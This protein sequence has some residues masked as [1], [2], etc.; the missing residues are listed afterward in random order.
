M[1]AGIQVNAPEDVP[2]SNPPLKKNDADI[3]ASRS[4]SAPQAR[5][6]PLKKFLQHDG[7][8][9]RYN[10][11]CSYNK[12]R[13]I[14]TISMSSDLHKTC[15]TFFSLKKKKI[16]LHLGPARRRRH[17]GGWADETVRFAILPGRRHDPDYWCG[18]WKQSETRIV[19]FEPSPRSSSLSTSKI[20]QRYTLVYYS[21]SH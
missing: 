17:I 12:N 19:Q 9:L 2:E 18:I 8:I 5:N 16:W 7:Q 14:F 11:L 10:K 13:S 6:H 21:P 4:R 3:A 15:K 1:S 20:T